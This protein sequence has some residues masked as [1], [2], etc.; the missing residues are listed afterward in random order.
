M[1]CSNQIIKDDLVIYFDISDIKSYDLNTSYTVQS[2]NSW[3]N[4]TTSVFNLPDFGLTAVDNG[5]TDK[6]TDDFS[7]DIFD[8]NLKLYRVGKNDSSGTTIYNGLDINYIPSTPPS[9]SFSGGYLQNFFKLDGYDYE[10]LPYRYKD[11]ITLEFW[12]KF[13]NNS[14]SSITNEKDGFFA[15]LGARAENK[16]GVLF[17]GE[18]NVTTSS[19]YTLGPD[20]LNL[21]QD[22]Y[23]NNIGFRITNDQKIGYRYINQSGFT[24]ENYSTASLPST[25]WTHIAITYEPYDDEKYISKFNMGSSG[26]ITRFNRPTYW[27]DVMDCIP[28]RNGALRFYVNGKPFFK[29]E[30]FSEQFWFKYLDTENQKQIGVPYNISIG[31]GTFGLKNSWHFDNLSNCTNLGVS[32]YNNYNNPIYSAYTCSINNFFS[33]NSQSI[34]DNY[35]T[36]IYNVYNIQIF[37][38]NLTYSKNN[39]NNNLLIEKNYDGTFI[40]EFNKFRFYLKPLNINMIQ[41]N[42]NTEANYFGLKQIKGGRVIYTN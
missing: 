25:G 23:D 18:T 22:I 17:S 29:E 1:S 6:L 33:F 21:E 12:L 5:R 31:G 3:K 16:Y 38:N 32:I 11:G 9:L 7:F 10:L 24:V 39:I 30:N 13:N 42:F 35:N 2:L 27:E 41:N 26:N 40:G 19:G 4:N 8:K 15:F 36:P 20:N 37:Q 28:K 34:F 14:F